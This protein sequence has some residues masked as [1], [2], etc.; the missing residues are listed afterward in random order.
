MTQIAEEKLHQSLLISL[1]IRDFM[2]ELSLADTWRQRW[3]AKQLGIRLV[4]SDCEHLQEATVVNATIDSWLGVSG[5][6]IVQKYTE[7]LL[8]PADSPRWQAWDSARSQATFGSTAELLLITMSDAW[9]RLVFAR[10]RQPY[11]DTTSN[12]FNNLT[13]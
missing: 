6:R 1:P 13:N 4:G 8:A 3:E 2:D 12:K 7:Q 11:E 10:K 5:L 9:R